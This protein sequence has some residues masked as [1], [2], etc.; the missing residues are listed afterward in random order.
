LRP[1]T[2]ERE[3]LLCLRSSGRHG[4]DC[5]EIGGAVTGSVMTGVLASAFAATSAH[6]MRSTV[7]QVSRAASHVF[8]NSFH[9][10]NGMRAE[11]LSRSVIFAM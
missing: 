8:V 9:F 10:D 5:P 6:P 7:D 11:Y 1:A 2:V 4:G 3:H